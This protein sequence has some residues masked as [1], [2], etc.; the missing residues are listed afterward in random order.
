[1]NIDGTNTLACLKPVAESVTNGKIKIYPLPHLRT[2][3]PRTLSLHPP[4]CD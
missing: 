4:S 3:S 1:M 2:R